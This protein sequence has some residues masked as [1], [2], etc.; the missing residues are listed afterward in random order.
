MC[1][2]IKITDQSMKEPRSIDKGKGMRDTP[3]QKK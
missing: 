1:T 2:E 3:R